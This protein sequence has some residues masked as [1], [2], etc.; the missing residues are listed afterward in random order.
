MATGLLTGSVT[1]S[2]NTQGKTG[3]RFE[4]GGQLAVPVNTKVRII[5]ETTGRLQA[6]PVAH[7]NVKFSIGGQVVAAVLLVHPLFA[8]ARTKAGEH[9]RARCAAR[10]TIG[11]AQQFA[12]S[13]V[14]RL[15][16]IFQATSQRETLHQAD[17]EFTADIEVQ[18]GLRIT[19]PTGRSSL[20]PDRSPAPPA[21]RGCILPVIDRD[22]PALRLVAQ[23]EVDHPGNGIR[24][25]LGSGAIA[26]HLDAAQRDR[27]NEIDA[28]GGGKLKLG[29][30]SFSSR[31]VSVKPDCASCAAAMTSIGTGLSATVRPLRRVPVTMIVSAAA[32]AVSS[33][34]VCA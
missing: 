14:K 13:D 16:A 25:I 27:R 12:G 18:Q 11:I 15:A 19:Q 30:C 10:R 21:Q 17:D 29:N 6:E 32:L 20:V 7:I 8:D 22:S 4:A 28:D 24:T 2:S 1:V 3:N 33:P 34:V 26:Q 9:L 31:L 5:L 23:L